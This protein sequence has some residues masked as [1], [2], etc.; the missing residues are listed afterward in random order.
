MLKLVHCILDEKFTKLIIDEF[1]FL[2][3]RCI[4]KYVLVTDKHQGDY[5]YISNLKNIELLGVEDFLR[6]IELESCNYVILHNFSSLN[7]SLLTKIPKH[8]RVVWFS[9]GMDIYG[10]VLNKP[11]VYI[12][13]MYHDETQKL[14]KPTYKEKIQRVK[15]WI[16]RCLNK[17][18]IKK[19]VNRVD[20]Y[21]G[22]ISEEY[23]MMQR[24]S[25][26]NAKPVDFIYASPYGGIDNTLLDDE[27]KLGNDIL[28]GN[29][30]D[31][32]NN[33]A[34]IF[35]K[36]KDI[37]LGKRKV[38]VPLSYAGSKRYRDQIKSMGKDIWGD[39]FLAI[40]NFMPLQEYEEIISSCGFRIF[41]QERQQAM[42]NISMALRNGCK[43]FVYKSS[44]IYKHFEKYQIKMYS[45]EED[46]NSEGLKSLP[47]EEDTYINRKRAIELASS[48]EQQKRLHRL[49]DYFEEEI[50]NKKDKQ[51]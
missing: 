3:D 43:V 51:N 1:E 22:V 45:I 42:G 49:I 10:K 41:G 46:L 12:P 36:L 7:Y 30:G 48:S 11:F 19:A 6:F 23:D 38:V 28:V 2:S 44:I 25:F 39:N 8:I 13:H 24:L 34:D 17:N 29:S 35:A 32:R 21:S 37:D 5:K 40:E 20:Y 16:N 27:P 50:Y 33:H 47:S 14:I 4:S 31:P 9:W 15:G 18:I 26:F